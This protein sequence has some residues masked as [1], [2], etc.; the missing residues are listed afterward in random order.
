MS[1]GGIRTRTDIQ[2]LTT[3]LNDWEAV[4][5]STDFPEMTQNE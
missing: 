5:K 3:N 1:L 2:A 4:T